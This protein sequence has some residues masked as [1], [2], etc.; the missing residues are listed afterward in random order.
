MDSAFLA[1][2]LGDPIEH[3]SAM[4][5]FLMG[6][7]IGLAAAVAVVAVVGTG[8]AALGVIAAV[9]GVVAATG[10]GALAGMNIG[11]T[12]T[13]VTGSITTGA[14]TVF[15][16]NRPAARATAAPGGFDIT[17]CS[18]HS[19]P[20]F[21]AQGSQTVFIEFGAASR[22]GDRTICDAKIADGSPNV[23]IGADPGTY[24]DISPEVPQILQ[25]IA[26]GM[27]VVGTAVALLAGGAAAFAAGGL[28]GL[29]SFGLTTALGMAGGWG[30][31]KLGGA[32]GETLG[33]ERGKAW[34]EAIGGILGGAAGGYAGNK[35]GPRVFR[36]HPVDVATGELM[37]QEVD[38]DLP[39]P[40]PLTW[41]RLWFSSSTIDGDLGRGWHHPLDMALI[42]PGGGRSL[43]ILRHADGRYV[44]FDLP[45]PGRPSLNTAE[46][47]ALHGDGSR[48]WVSDYEG[49][50]FDFSAEDTAG[51]RRLVRIA[52]LNDNAITIDRDAG[53]R[54]RRITDSGGRVL[55]VHS[56]AAGRILAVDGPAPDGEG[57]LRLVDYRYDADG[58]LLQ[59]RRA[60]GP[61]FSYAYQGNLIVAETR[62]GGVT[63]HFEWDDPDLGV[64]ARC[65]DTWG[66][67]D[68]FRCRFA[69][70][71]AARRTL[72]Q[73]G[74]GG[75]TE[76]RWNDLGLVTQ[77]IDP[78][79][80]R[81]TRDHDD[82]GRPILAIDP[83]G[84]RS[85]WSYDLLGRLVETT[86]PMGG[87]T[88]LRYAA[89][90]LD[91]LAHPG[92][93][94]PVEIEEPGGARH[95]FEYDV[96]SNLARYVDPVGRERR[97]TRDLRGLT[98][99]ITDAEGVL[100]RYGWTGR[101]D[102][103][104]EATERGPRKRFAHD[105]LGQLVAS[106]TAGE[107]ATRLARDDA[108][109]VVAIERP[110]GGTVTL[111]YDPEGRIIRHRD[112]A[113]RETGWVYDGLSVPVRR[114]DPDGSVFAYRYDG[115]LNLVGLTNQ[116][117]ETYRI[118]YDAAGRVVREVG[119]DGREQRYS[120]DARG[121][122]LRHDDAGL[123]T[124]VF[125]RDALGRMLEKRFGDSTTHR[126]RYDRAGRLVEAVNDSR[127]LGFAYDAAGDL[128]EEHQDGHML[129][130]RYDGRG[131]LAATRL[132]DGR[133]IGVG[134]DDTD[135][136]ATVD[137][138][139]RRVAEILR[140]DAGREVERRTGA[141]RSLREYDPQGR[142]TRQAAWKD[143]EAA[144]PL[145]G[146]WYRYDPADLIVSIGDWQRGVR[147]YRYDACER[148]LQ[149]TGDRPEEFVLDPA[150]N[151][152]ASGPAADILGGAARGDRL[153]V[154]G[155]RH[156]EYDACGNRVRETRGAGG[157]VEVRY[158]YGPDNQ[159]VSVVE[160]SRLGRRE[161]AFAYDALGRR[162]RKEAWTWGSEP[163]N[164][165][166]AG[167]PLLRE[168]RTSFLWMGD[169]LLSEAPSKPGED[170]ADPLATVYLFEP[171][172]FRPLA[173]VRRPAAEQ[174]GSV[175]HYHCD[176]LGT[177]QELTDDGGAIVWR[178][179]LK[180][181]G[182]LAALV[183]AEVENPLRFPGQ[184][185][186]AETG[187]HYNRYRYYAPEEGCFIHQDPI[188]LMGGAN[189]AA[190]A[191][192]PV[193]WIDPWG[194]AK[195]KYNVSSNSAGQDALARGVHVNV[196]GPGLP[197][198]GG[199][200]GLAPNPDY[201]PAKPGSP[202]VIMRPED[203]AT[204]A[205]SPSQWRKVQEAVTQHLDDPK[206]VNTVAKQAQSSL[207]TNPNSH[208]AT[209]MKQMK[210][211]L[212]DA[213]ETGVNPCK[214]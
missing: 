85:T 212:Q 43:F 82:A 44:P 34:G 16:N 65:V 77:E 4:M 133:E 126:F 8:G 84:G 74:R 39:G 135:R 107:G 58:H 140:D 203:P 172:S 205:L 128:L 97:F 49:R 189:L 199:H 103:S 70:D 166:G 129:Q 202:R 113:G 155:D 56:D 168:G 78:L 17:A 53:G 15:I 26:L 142:L 169:L 192:N 211:K 35:L 132:P 130:H 185:H 138:D 64:Q 196:D 95:A 188:G 28:C 60:G 162:V 198:K 51:L 98:L 23:F 127:A 24:R 71:P 154:H 141:L 131:R 37:T 90:G 146:R 46:Q 118:D 116:K 21:L 190:Y 89:E 108:G 121:S 96:R 147:N 32:I 41:S 175:Y 213:L 50:R 170:P 33:G 25:D 86:D 10:G 195:S 173:Q 69:Y 80:G 171:G 63:Y 101:G 214:A 20:Q 61:V 93:G 150:G 112:A 42:P 122:L 111:D 104:W 2:R 11:S 125:R 184:Y 180:A 179:D 167:E 66:D 76:Y 6:A 157:G 99:A 114:V 209:E 200:V 36:G 206:N 163:A 31:A 106:Q 149:V 14:S 143:G 30:G 119:F 137:F 194:W 177:P 55:D 18:D 183:V 120:Y 105:A 204:K 3:S 7:A 207:D 191:L 210:S 13:T 124:T 72:V 59:A 201:D 148:L 73:D 178:G 83:A 45:R 123:R 62:P 19:G 136:F 160:S 79:G 145:L 181:W 109:R 87:A 22:K 94:L 47:L 27:V 139:G 174:S 165:P 164:A 208:R 153:L 182:A 5:G 115:E 92:F 1:A 110:D 151:I 187:L 134:Y 75:V 197:R 9:G 57:T 81:T 48:L 186:D 88:R 40:L 176:H 67:G 144:K 193:L 156:F 159:L 38:F 29:G 158:A 52:D 102:L 54:M 68:L 91:A 100:A 161:T 117:G 12:Y 152:L